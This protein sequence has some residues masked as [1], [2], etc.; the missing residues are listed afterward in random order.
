YAGAP[1]VCGDEVR[2]REIMMNVVA[3]A[4][5]FTEAGAI[6]VRARASGEMVRIEVSDTGVGIPSDQLDAVFMEFQQVSGQRSAGE[7]TGLGM[8][9][10][11][12]LVELHGG[13]IWLESRSGVGTTVFITLPVAEAASSEQA[14]PREL[15]AAKSS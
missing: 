5:K 8:P 12:R 11:K 1:S 3:N 15:E 13:R 9:I 2:V 4:C 7:G 10:A 14:A 6:T